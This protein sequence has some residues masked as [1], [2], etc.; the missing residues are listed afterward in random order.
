[1]QELKNA[2]EKQLEEATKTVK[3]ASGFEL[4]ELTESHPDFPHCERFVVELVN[5]MKKT[6]V[7]FGFDVQKTQLVRIYDK[8]KSL[9]NANELR[10]RD[11]MNSIR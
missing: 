5:K 10:C 8:Y 1:M 6:I 9:E 2:I 3:N 4:F 11:I 7:S